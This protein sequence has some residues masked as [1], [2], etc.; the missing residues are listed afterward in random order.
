MSSKVER[1]LANWQERARIARE[2]NNDALAA[3]CDYLVQEYQLLLKSEEEHEN[4]F[5]LKA[6]RLRKMMEAS[7]QHRT[8]CVEHGLSDS[9]ID[10]TYEIQ[11]IERKIIALVASYNA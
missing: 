10:A 5:L 2:Y 7:E 11:E 6:L 3:A 1:E 8:M 9:A 4:E